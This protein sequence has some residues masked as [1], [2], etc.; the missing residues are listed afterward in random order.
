MFLRENAIYVFLDSSNLLL[1]ICA[2]F[3][4][5]YYFPGAK[6]RFFPRWYISEE[7]FRFVINT[8]CMS[9]NVKLLCSPTL[10]FSSYNATV[11]ASRDN[12]WT[13]P[14]CGNINFSFRTVCN[15]RKCNTP[16]PGSQVCATFFLN[17][18]ESV[19]YFCAWWPFFFL[20]SL[21]SLG[22]WTWDK[23]ENYWEFKIIGLV[24]SFF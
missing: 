22:H 8:M 4:S 12:D 24:C 7:G 5:A 14:K 11:D 16:K 6:A 1:W 13:C 20:M 18:E 9:N 21:Y 15:M 3:I 19:N 10:I 17:I 23:L 2:W